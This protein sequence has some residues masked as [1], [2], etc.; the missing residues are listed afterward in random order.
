MKPSRRWERVT[1]E[2]RHAVLLVWV[3]LPAASASHIASVFNRGQA[4]IYKMVT[5]LPRHGMIEMLD[6]LE[7]RWRKDYP[8]GTMEKFGLSAVA[9]VLNA[10]EKMRLA[11][12]QHLRWPP[13]PEGK[14][15]ALNGNDDS[16]RLQLV[17][18]LQSMERFT[19]KANRLI[20]AA[21]RDLEPV[22]RN[23]ASA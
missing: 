7:G 6:E 3:T 14:V 20:S 17:A 11:Q 15:P 9:G 4:T 22:A 1:P 5:G 10:L 19:D 2:M 8:A 23:G 13:Y 12:P 18:W 16:I 21:A